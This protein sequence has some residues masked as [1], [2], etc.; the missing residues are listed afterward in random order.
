MANT[1]R[2]EYMTSRRADKRRL[3]KLVLGELKNTGARFIRRV[4]SNGQTA[5][6]WEEV[7]DETAFK[8]VSH[9]LRLRTKNESNREDG[10]MVAAR[11]AQRQ[12]GVSIADFDQPTPRESTLS[13]ASD[14]EVVGD[15]NGA[16]STSQRRTPPTETSA[17]AIG[18]QAEI[19]TATLSSPLG[20]GQPAGRVSVPG[21][22][23]PFAHSLSN[24]Q[25][26]QYE[27]NHQ[28]YL[29]IMLAF[30]KQS[31]R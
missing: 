6:E 4:A 26:M 29:N 13:A 19:Q 15:S 22:L 21:Q 14:P 1:Y 18:Q 16:S 30:L 23:V 28:A 31:Q 11:A 20:E 7:D 24:E 3:T 27:A 2:E 10:P 17:P 8:K 5:D 9:A 12:A 25:R